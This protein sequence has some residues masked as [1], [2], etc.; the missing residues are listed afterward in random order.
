[1]EGWRGANEPPLLRSWLRAAVET[2]QAWHYHP[3]M[4]RHWVQPAVDATV[5]VSRR[6]RADVI[7]A[8]IGPASSG[9]VARRASSRTGVPYVL[10]FRDPWGLDYYDAE[11]RRPAWVKRADR[12]A[13]HRMFENAQAVV[14]QFAAVAACYWHA[15]PGAL[16]A[17]RIHIIPNGYE[18]TVQESAMPDLDRCTALYAGTL[19]TYYR[20]DSLLEALALLKKHCGCEARQ[21]RIVFVGDTNG[22]AVH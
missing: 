7:W 19:S 16:D 17:N 4:A 15:Y 18:G 9:I 1:M 6:N 22:G 20:Y 21:L 11:V 5:E 8:T 13:F 10:D 2:A 12:L 14:F 3:D